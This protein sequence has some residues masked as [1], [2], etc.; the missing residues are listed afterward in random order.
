MTTLSVVT[1]SQFR[2]ALDGTA[3]ERG[4][5]RSS[6]TLTDKVRTRLG[7]YGYTLTQDCGKDPQ[8]PAPGEDRQTAASLQLL[9]AMDRSD[10][11]QMRRCL[12]LKDTLDNNEEVSLRRF[13][14]NLIEIQVDSRYSTLVVPLREIEW[15]TLPATGQLVLAKEDKQALTV[16]V[17]GGKALSARDV[18]ARLML[19]SGFALPLTT[20]VTGGRHVQITFPTL[21]DLGTTAGAL[22]RT[23]LELSLDSQKASYTLRVLP[24]ERPATSTPLRIDSA[25][26]VSDEGGNGRVS[27]AI[28]KL[29][30][31]V[32]GK[33][34]L[35]VTGA[36][37]RDNATTAAGLSH[38]G[39]PLQPESVL[40]LGL[41]NLSPARPVV[42]TM[43][44]DDV[45]LGEGVQIPV[46][47]SRPTASAR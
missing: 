11:N 3:P 38:W 36:D 45:K 43:F 15:P 14:A 9:R 39:M 27:L 6:E 25:V 13:L 46:E 30:D 21:A 31:G 44:A 20:G 18:G 2:S 37:V 22:P 1:S 4:S 35:T 17:R 40:T 34:R 7:Q 42:F 8:S 33:L 23:P 32:K 41:A 47:R 5:E 10:Y 12:G 28:G 24:G 16:V 26:I 29:P 19:P